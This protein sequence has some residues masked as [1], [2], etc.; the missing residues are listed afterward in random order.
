M[1]D[2]LMLAGAIR[3]VA[4]KATGSAHI[5]LWQAINLFGSVAIAGMMLPPV[6]EDL[7]RWRA[8]MTDRD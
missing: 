4:T 2:G 5:E 1:I 7:K 8:E 6:V 3:H